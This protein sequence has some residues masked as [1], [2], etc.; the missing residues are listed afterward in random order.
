MTVKEAILQTLEDLKTVLNYNEIYNHIVS[1]QYYEFT[2]KTPTSTVAG[3]LSDF[4]KFAD[5]RVKRIKTQGGGYSY[6]LTKY[7]S[8]IPSEVLSGSSETETEQ[9]TPTKKGNYFERD[10]HILL[11]SYL[12]NSLI[13]TKTIYH[14]KSNAKDP[15]QKW[16]HP[17]MV[18]LK[19]R[20]L[21][22]PISNRLIKK[23]N[24][25]SLVNLYSFEIKKEINNDNELKQAYFQAVSNSSW[26][27]FGYL[28]AFEI[29]TSLHGELERLN[30]TNGIGVI[31]L[32]PNPFESRILI[33]ARYRDLD[34]K[35]I[36]KL[37]E[38]NPDFSGFMDHVDNLLSADERFQPSLQKDLVDFCD[39][40][41][42]PESEK[43]YKNYLKEKNI[44]DERLI[45]K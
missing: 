10:L 11:S 22:N 2:G 41:F 28:V 1:K 25:N 45:N 13:H 20:D 7:E 8:L 26:A 32:N 19:F 43:E 31:E 3:Y 16:T 27:H 35:T 18:G 38:M 39:N 40:Y 23:L 37:M 42:S 29:S 33:P 34:F 15:V 44:P 21:K 14:E 9:A 4:I 12:R 5:T 6:Y 17:D 24:S 36:D 30:E